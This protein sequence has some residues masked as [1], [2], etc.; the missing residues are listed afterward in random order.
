MKN[1]KEF[2]K[3]L[4]LL[5]VGGCCYYGIEILWR[6]YSH[7]TMAIVGGFC[8]VIIGGLNNYIP[9]KMPIWKQG[10]VG[11][12]FVTSME[13]VVGIPLNIFMGMNIWDYS[14]I[15]FNFMGQICLIY[16]LLWIPL[17]ILCVFLDDFL[18]YK[19][20]KEER[21]KYYL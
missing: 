19:M 3:C 20:F 1:I 8:F 17:S 13:L 16:S 9:W 10:I 21:P 18:R 5:L 7:W 15:P 4:I 12:V 6:G 14:Q 2:L 11:S